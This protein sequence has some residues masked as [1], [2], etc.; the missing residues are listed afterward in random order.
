ME[1]RVCSFCGN[2]L[3]PG[4][5]RL[6]VRRDGTSFY[7][8]SKRCQV[9]LLKQ[10]KIPRYVKWTR[11]YPRHG[12]EAEAELAK[13]AAARQAEVASGAEEVEAEEGAPE[14]APEPAQEPTGAT[15]RKR[16]KPGA[17][18][19]KTK[20]PGEKKGD[21][22]AAAK[23]EEPAEDETESSEDEGEGPEADKDGASD[24]EP[25]GAEAEAEEPAEKASS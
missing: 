24:E 14:P 9:K 11:H 6:F 22:P 13:E 5:G 12:E 19:P 2:P 1:Q 7:F 16:E 3:E 8:D 10:G 4:T 20:E 21:L 23:K 18:P 17:E 15:G 25:E